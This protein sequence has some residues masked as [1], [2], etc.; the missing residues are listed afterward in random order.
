MGMH[1]LD[2]LIPGMLVSFGTAAI[3]APFV[4]MVWFGIAFEPPNHWQWK[5]PT[6]LYTFAVASFIDLI[7]YILFLNF[8]A[9]VP[10]FGAVPLDLPLR[11]WIFL[12]I[13]G[14]VFLLITALF[15]FRFS[16]PGKRVLMVGS[17]ILFTVNLIGFIAH[18]LMPHNAP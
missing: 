16:G 9:V 5:M 13:V 2:F 7:A 18:Q 3:G 8:P 15:L 11:M 6:A 17:G 12:M 1:D 14:F 4:A 10:G